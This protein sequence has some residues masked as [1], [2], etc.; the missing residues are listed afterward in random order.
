[1]L[2]LGFQRLALGEIEP[3]V[4]DLLGAAKL[5]LRLDAAGPA[6]D[7]TQWQDALNETVDAA[8]RHMDPGAFRAFV[9]DVRSALV[10]AAGNA[11]PG[12]AG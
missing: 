10:P 1:M 11:G 5:Q 12:L 2:R 9:D 4:R 7:V 8:R 6:P 3:D